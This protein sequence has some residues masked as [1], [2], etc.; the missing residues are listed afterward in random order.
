MNEKLTEISQAL[1]RIEG[2]LDTNMAW[3]T[4]HAA[5]DAFVHAELRKQRGFI[6][7]AASAFIAIGA[8]IAYAAKRIL[9]H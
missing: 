3:Q 6:A 8:G 4:R 2:K 1:E 9:G 7:G 5:E